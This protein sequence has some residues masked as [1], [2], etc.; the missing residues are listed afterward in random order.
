MKIKSSSKLEIEVEDDWYCDGNDDGNWY[1]GSTCTWY[2]V[3]ENVATTEL[4]ADNPQACV[5]AAQ[6][7]GMNVV[8]IGSENRFN[9]N[10]I[11]CFVSE[12][13]CGDSLV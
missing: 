1:M 6:E 12:D 11:T 5:E 13:I 2:Q 4:L 7:L 8:T 3:Y 9:S 10:G